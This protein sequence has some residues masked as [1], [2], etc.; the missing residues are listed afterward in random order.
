MNV[1]KRITQDELERSSLSYRSA[2]RIKRFL[3][4]YHLDAVLG[5]LFPGAGDVVLWLSALPLLYV[6]LI[7]VGSVRLTLAILSNVLVDSLIGM[8]PLLGDV[9]DF[10]FKAHRRS[11]TLLEGFVEGDK[12]II[13]EVNKR[14]TISI[15]TIIV[16]I[17]LIGL[18]LYLFAHLL[19]Q[20]YSYLIT[21]I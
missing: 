7:K 13:R 16:C 12:T 19:I 10:L 9:A 4:D 20:F 2:K 8:V 17:I 18:L 14:A 6:A 21:L 15:I 1:P 5:F 3:D 11:F